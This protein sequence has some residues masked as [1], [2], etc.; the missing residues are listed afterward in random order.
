MKQAKMVGWA[1]PMIGKKRQTI[2]AEQALV[3]RHNADLAQSKQCPSCG[4]SAFK[5]K[6]VKL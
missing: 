4:S 2:R 1:T 6:R 3:E 5:D